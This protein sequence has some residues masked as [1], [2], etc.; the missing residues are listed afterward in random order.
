MVIHGN[1]NILLVSVFNK[2]VELILIKIFHLKT[3]FKDKLLIVS[4]K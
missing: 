1:I 2:M 3:D 4:L